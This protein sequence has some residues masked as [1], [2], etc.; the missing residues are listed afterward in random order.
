LIGTVLLLV[1]VAAWSLLAMAFAQIVAVRSNAVLE[2]IYYLLAGLGWAVPAMPLI[3]WMYRTP[4]GG[5]R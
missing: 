5:S 2:F 3:S 1:L 4:A